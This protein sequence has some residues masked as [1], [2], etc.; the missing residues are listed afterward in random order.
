MSET[1]TGAASALAGAPAWARPPRA[2]GAADVGPDTGLIADLGY[3]SVRLI[4]LAIAL[5]QRFELPA[6]D[7]A[8][9]IAVCTVADVVALVEQQRARR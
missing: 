3:D 1:V 6:L 9:S 4:E 8:G 2:G 7:E 5:E